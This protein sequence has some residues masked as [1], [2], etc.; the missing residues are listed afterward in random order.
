M[1]DAKKTQAQ[2]VEELNELRQQVIESES[3]K[4]QLSRANHD[5]AERTR[6]LDAFQQ[7]AQNIL[8]SLE[9]EQI[10]DN[11]AEQI[12][13]AGVYRSLMVALVDEQIQKVE[14]VRGLS[15]YA[16]GR[17]TLLRP[18][19]AYR[20]I[21]LRYDLDDDNILAEVARTGEKQVVEGWDE[22]FEQTI[23]R[24]GSYED[25]ISY[26]IPIKQKDRVLAIIATGSRVKEKEETLQ[27][28][29]AMQP[30]LDQVAVALEHARMYEDIRGEM[31]ERQRVEL[32][33]RES[34]GRIRA[35]MDTI[36]DG[37]ITIDAQGI[38]ETVNS[39]AERIFGYASSELTGQNVRMLMPEPYHGEHDGYLANYLETGEARII[40]IGREVQGRRKDGSIFPL[41]LAVSEVDGGDGR[42]FT[43]VVRDITVR[44][45]AARA[46]EQAREQAEVANQA[47]S[48]F[49][50]TMSHELRTP[51]N[52]IIGFTGILLQ[53]LA[54][55]LNEEQ[56]KQLG[57]AYGSASH[58][59]ALINDI[60]DISKIEA[61]E[62]E[63][64]T[65]TFPMSE[66]VEE[67]MRTMT[68]LTE[69]KKLVL[70]TELTSE[71]GPITSDRRRVKQILVNLVNNAVKFTEKGAVRVECR[72]CDD[73][74]VTCVSDT[75]I[76][77]KS[78][79]LGKLFESFQQ[80]ETGLARNYEGTGL[81]LSI[82]KRLV[83]ML[84]GEIWI[85]SE[86]AVGSTV[87]FTLPVDPGG[88]HET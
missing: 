54:G 3:E 46:L 32:A 53:G 63:V 60:L 71:V 11:L 70:S 69:K 15:R 47:K 17:G 45:Q 36:V 57:M 76:G 9:L 38:I 88:W 35:M 51:L 14:V 78:E 75:G 2:L 26:F 22:R 41:D 31:A 59:L 82:C 61:G 65:E 4:A 77:I 16:G 80:I 58:L 34:E 20:R 6:Q 67:V 27:R 42:T 62:I 83:E 30:L 13:E 52:S 66:V 55:P 33:A 25:R 37:I 21:G 79:D 56:S 39:A 86:W 43:G 50:A 84:G 5:L 23:E 12:M 64:V 8:S 85:E 87:T 1:D 81:G 29:E 44:Q 40:G 7:I 49:L 24:Q 73:Q 28:I 10:L 68:P 18:K 48:E 74:L 72:I 19:I